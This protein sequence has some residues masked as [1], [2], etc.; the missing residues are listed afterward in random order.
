MTIYNFT[1]THYRD[2][3]LDA[4]MEDRGGLLTQAMRP[5]YEKMRRVKG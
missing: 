2:A 1:L 3:K 4:I 5:I